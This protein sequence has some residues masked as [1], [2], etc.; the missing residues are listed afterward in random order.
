MLFMFLLSYS[1]NSFA[2]LIQNYNLLYIVLSHEYYLIT[3]SIG[4]Y[5]LFSASATFLLVI[6]PS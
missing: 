6:L 1:K 2:Y 3:S 4:M 5:F